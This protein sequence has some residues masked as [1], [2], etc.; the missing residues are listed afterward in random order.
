MSRLAW[1]WH[2]LGAMNA[3]EIAQRLRKKGVQFIDARKPRDWTSVSLPAGARYPLLPDPNRAP[4][5]LR[6]SLKLD[7]DNIL[8]GHWRAFG[9][10]PIQVTDPPQWHEDYLA[11]VDLASNASA[12]DLD[13]RS[14]PKGADIKLIWELSR[15]YQLTR[16]A[17]SAH[18]HG[19]K[20]AAWKCVHWLEH[21]M[22]HNPPYRGWNWTSALEAGLRLI[23]FTWIDALLRPFSATGQGEAELE[24]L[25]YEVLPAHVWF[26]WRHKSFGSSANN[27]LL[28]ELAGL[29][30]ATVRWPELAAWGAPIDELHRLWEH[31][32]IAQFAEDGGNREQAL[33]YHLF[34]FEFCWHVRQALVSAGRTV[35][36]AVETRLQRAAQFFVNVHGNRE[37]WDY[38]DS[39]DAYVL[40]LF[41]CEERATHEWCEWMQGQDGGVSF[42]IG[43]APDI[44]RTG[45]STAL[46]WQSYPDSGVAILEHNELFLRF[47]ASPLGYLAT[48]AHGH[49]DALHLSLWLDNV[50]MV[51]DPG[52]GAYYGDE[53]LRTWLASRRAHNGPCPDGGEWPRRLGPFLWS[54]HHATPTLSLKGSVATGE[55][56]TPAGI[57]KRSIT[58]RESGEVMVEDSVAGSAA[59]F[60]VLWQFAPESLCEKLDARRFRIRRRGQSLEIQVSESWDIVDPVS[61][62]PRKPD[63]F[64]GI[65]SPGFRQS[66]WAPFLKLTAKAGAK[67]CLFTTTFLASR[68]P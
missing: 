55:W 8:R 17:M 56:P 64:E 44:S 63:G 18:V 5:S 27:H 61:V 30:L 62:E 45:S 29:I 37:A 10:L 49:L 16:L 36:T 67:P 32:V 41:I 22:R 35:S 25:R 26:A 46:Q 31:E 43:K 58:T 19:D 60:S 42:W 33:H 39:D 1:Y 6:E 47:D 28:G 13:H 4:K 59:S 7:S 40:P 2:R 65:V 51:I 53:R 57:M 38:G 11:G 34:S 23:Q 52:T 50:A 3:G 9:H 68:I 20:H 66:I 15:W 48:A 14:L 24:Q 54:E 12:F 21:W